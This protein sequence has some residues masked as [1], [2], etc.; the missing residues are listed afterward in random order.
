MADSPRMTSR[1]I[2]TPKTQRVTSLI[3]IQMAKSDLHNQVGFYRVSSS[4]EC[5]ERTN[6][7]YISVSLISG[8]ET[9]VTSR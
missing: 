4:Q 6:Y 1:A 9:M 2:I 5:R 8:A 3:V 7:T